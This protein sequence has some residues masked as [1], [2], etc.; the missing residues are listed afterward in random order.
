MRLRIARPSGTWLKPRA[1]ILCGGRRTML[2]P[3]KSIVP[4]AGRI[5]PE[6]VFSS[7]VLPAPLAPISVTIC[8]CSIESATSCSTSI[9]P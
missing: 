5:S 8:P 3:S 9:L 6:M 2:S 1:T 7:V 4:A